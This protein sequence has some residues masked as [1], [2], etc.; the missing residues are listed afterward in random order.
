MTNTAKEDDIPVS[1]GVL[2]IFEALGLDDSEELLAKAHLAQS[3]TSIIKHRH[4]TQAD[5]AKLLET[6]QPKI[7]AL[8]NGRIAGFSLERLVLMMNKLDHDVEISVRKKPSSRSKAR[9]SVCVDDVFENLNRK[10]E[11]GSLFVAI[12]DGKARY[13]TSQA[14]P[15]MLER[16]LPDGSVETGKLVDGEF[17]ISD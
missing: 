10:K 2:N 15:G 1:E 17:V 9:L 6:K 12:A 5:A 8:M 13:Q 16:V 14:H 11:D 4:L 7:S 3:V